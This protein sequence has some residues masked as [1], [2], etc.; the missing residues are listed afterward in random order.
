MKL[1]KKQ[2]TEACDE[3]VQQGKLVKINP[4]SKTPSWQE[5][6]SYLDNIWGLTNRYEI[7]EKCKS[8]VDLMQEEFLRMNIG[9]YWVYLHA[10]C[11]MPHIGF[12]AI[13]HKYENIKKVKHDSPNPHI[14]TKAEK[15][16][17]IRYFKKN[18]GQKSITDESKSEP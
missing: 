3:L 1:T 8:S 10:Q 18:F 2:I 7:C 4:D 13:K 11:T 5:V 16:L 9:G 12:F 6:E 14:M 17:V 15:D